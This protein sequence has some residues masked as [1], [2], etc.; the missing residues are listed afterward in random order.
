MFQI[1]LRA[2]VPSLLVVLLMGSLAAAQSDNELSKK[3]KKWL[4]EEVGAIITAHE[5]KIFTDI[6]K[7]DRKLF[8]KIFWSRRDPNPAS[9]DNEFEKAFE[10]N[11]KQ[12]DKQYKVKGMKGSATD[13]GKVFCLLG[14]PSRVEGDAQAATWVYDPNP[15]LGLPDGVT[16]QF[17]AN[18][19]VPSEDLEKDL[20]RA[21]T[22]NISNPTVMYSIVEGRLL[23]PRGDFD[24]NSPANQILA[25]LRESKA[26]SSDVPFETTIAFFRASEG[27]IYIP[28]LFEVDEASL[29]WQGDSA[30]FTVFG[31]VENTDGFT[32]YQF[33]E[34][35]KV[36][37]SSDG[38]TLFE[39]PMQL[40]PGQYKLYLGVR[41]NPSATAGTQITDLEVP[42]YFSGEL[43]LSSVVDYNQG[44]EVTEQAGTP[45][46]AFQ[47]GK[48][49][50]QPTRIFTKQDAIGLFFFLYGLGVDDNGK[51]NVTGQ[52]VFYRGS[53]KKGQTGVEALPADAN[54]SVGNAEIPLSISNFDEPG[55]WRMHIIVK[56]KVLNKTLTTDVEFVLEGESETQ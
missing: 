52:Y 7:D 13:M 54:Q 11:A 22:R 29:T 43:V 39:V 56:D 50:F 44:K 27:S 32:I 48:V 37:K 31:S 41:D 2:L 35:A 17:Q 25:A 10:R 38:R 47:F 12:A 28:I 30:D 33:E 36:K 3:D 42:D 55:D 18:R 34:P 21:R 23:E 46:Q 15:Q 14:P 19:M 24:P 8:K 26:T 20:E 40:V 49:K 6:D 16:I 51:P 5:I 45:G 9:K 4:E 53:Q 1:S